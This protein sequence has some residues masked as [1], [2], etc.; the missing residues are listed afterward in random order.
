M[1]RYT[2]TRYVSIIFPFYR[3]YTIPLQASRSKTSMVLT[4]KIQTRIWDFSIVLLFLQASAT[5]NKTYIWVFTHCCVE[6]SVL[7]LCGRKQLTFCHPRLFLIAL[8]CEVQNDAFLQRCWLR[9]GV[10][11]ILRMWTLNSNSCDLCDRV[12]SLP[13]QCRQAVLKKFP[14]ICSYTVPWAFSHSSLHQVIL[15]FPL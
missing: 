2:E 11:L 7:F 4:S 14:N 9:T 6:V 3:N 13:I 15:R 1:Q 5:Y 12:G 8:K 10:V